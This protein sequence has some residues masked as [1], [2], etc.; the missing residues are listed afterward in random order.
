M[1]KQPSCLVLSVML[2]LSAPAQAGMLGVDAL[3]GLNHT[4]WFM[5]PVPT[6]STLSPGLGFNA[7]A[8]INFNPISLITVE[9]GGFYSTRSISVGFGP[10]TQSLSFGA[11]QI[12]F[13][14]RL[15][16]IPFLSLGFGGFYQMAIGSVNVNNSVTGASSTTFALA[17]LS[18]SSVGL[19]ASLQGR[20]NLPLTGLSV[21]GRVNYLFGLTNDTTVA[22]TFA[23]LRDLQFQAGVGY[24]FL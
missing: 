23:G 14:V 20:F 7:G 2:L 24:E 21:L 5:N 12:P 6:G 22:S 17:N 19:M 11:I 18:T 9:V 13:L 3:G 16:P 10:I 4:T 15:N 8:M 1:K